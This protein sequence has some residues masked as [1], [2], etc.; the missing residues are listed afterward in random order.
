[1][2]LAFFAMALLVSSTAFASK[3]PKFGSLYKATNCNSGVQFIEVN[4]RQYCAEIDSRAVVDIN[5]NALVGQNVR[6]NVGEIRDGVLFIRALDVL[7]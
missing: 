5:L 6:I 4:D 1:M 7:R 2:K 3:F